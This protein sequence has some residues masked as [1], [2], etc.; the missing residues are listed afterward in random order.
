MKNL[1]PTLFLVGGLTV[2]NFAWA[3]KACYEVQG[4]T[5]ATCG[6]TV[7]SAV[8]RIKG[9]QEVKASVEKK[10]AAV[11]FDPTQTNTDAIKK[12]IDDVGY[13]ATLHECTKTEG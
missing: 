2:T 8:K 13:K 4:M 5:C 3:E 12:A 9:I 7:K 1:I 6:I 11:Q 10:N